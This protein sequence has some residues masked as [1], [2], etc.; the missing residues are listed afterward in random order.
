MPVTTQANQTPAIYSV[1]DACALLSV[2]RTTLYALMARG[3]IKGRKI[4]RR[5]VIVASDLAAFVDQ[6]PEK[7]PTH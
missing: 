6:L 1:Q 7:H 2:S 5:T 3:E 4:G